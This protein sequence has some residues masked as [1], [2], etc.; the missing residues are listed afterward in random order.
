MNQAMLKRIQRL[1]LVYRPIGLR[2]ARMTAAELDAALASE[3]PEGELW[4]YVED[5]LKQCSD[6]ELEWLIADPTVRLPLLHQRV[7]SSL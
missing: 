6:A 2:V 3:S 5:C 1:E 7:T 4:Q